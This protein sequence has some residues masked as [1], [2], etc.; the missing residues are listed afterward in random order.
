MDP[1]LTGNLLKHTQTKT[2]TIITIVT[3]K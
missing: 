3:A 2:T 1:S